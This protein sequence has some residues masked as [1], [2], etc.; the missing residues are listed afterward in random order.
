MTDAPKTVEQVLAEKGV[1]V[2]TTVGSSMRPLFSDRRDTVILSPVKGRLKKYDVPLYRRGNR[3]ILHRIVRVTENG[4]VI[5]G[6]NCENREYDIRDENILGV[7]T[8]F[9]RKNKYHSVN[10]AGY[11][12]YSRIHVALYPVRKG[13]LFCRRMLGRAYHRLFRDNRQK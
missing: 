1:Y 12:M 5:C 10:D 4:Y 8:A 9:Y 7:M 13:I 2:S 6:D 3:L 11:L